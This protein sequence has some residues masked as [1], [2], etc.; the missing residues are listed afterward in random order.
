MVGSSWATTGKGERIHAF[1]W[2]PAHGMQDLGTSD[3]GLAEA[4]WINDGGQVVGWRMEGTRIHAFLWEPAHGMQDLGTLGGATSMA[5]YVNNAGQ[6]AGNADTL[7]GT[8]AFL[9]EAGRGMQDLGTLRRGDTYSD[10]L[11]VSNAVTS[12]K[13]RH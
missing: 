5:S 2:E 7:D 4:D 13:R 6:V 10:A 12:L 9:W 8:H 3:G 11:R 1:L